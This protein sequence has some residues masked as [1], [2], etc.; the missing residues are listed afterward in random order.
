MRV[1]YHLQGIAIISSL[2]DVLL[3]VLPYIIQLNK[4]IFVP[5]STRYHKLP[6]SFLKKLD[7]TLFK[8][9]MITRSNALGNRQLI[10]NFT[11]NV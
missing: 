10:T 5:F 11:K 8:K 1:L 7:N 9:L 2:S 3:Y 4:Y 6:S